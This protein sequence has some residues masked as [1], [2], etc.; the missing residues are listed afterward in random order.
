MPPAGRLS[1]AYHRVPLCRQNALVNVHIVHCVT[2]EAISVGVSSGV[3]GLSA[4]PPLETEL[5]PCLP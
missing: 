5:R 1:M 2:P 4:K 3:K